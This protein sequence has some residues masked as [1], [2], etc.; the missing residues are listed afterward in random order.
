MFATPIW[1]AKATKFVWLT[2]IELHSRKKT[3]LLVGVA[4][5]FQKQWRVKCS[6]GG[7]WV[8]HSSQQ[9]PTKKI[10]EHSLETEQ[11]WQNGIEENSVYLDI[12]ASKIFFR[13]T[14]FFDTI[15]LFL[16]PFQLFFAW[17][18]LKGKNRQF[19][20]VS[21]KLRIL[22]PMLW[23]AQGAEGTAK[24]HWASGSWWCQSW[25]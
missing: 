24:G 2:W 19:L 1:F 9:Q 14:P 13:G 17:C 6:I 23:V 4:S 11:V 8:L 21:R 22:F 25:W 15:S 10:P 16:W 3:S 12:C 7:N 5:G 20:M 18:C